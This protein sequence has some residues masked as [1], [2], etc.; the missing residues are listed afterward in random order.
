[1]GSSAAPKVRFRTTEG[2]A[3]STA[4]V[5]ARGN[6]LP[7][8]LAFFKTSCPI[9]QLT[10]P[11]LQRLHR[12]YGAKAVHVVGVSQNDAD[13]SRAYYAEHGGATFDLLLDS[14][15]TFAA[16]NAFGVESVPHLVLLSPE[17]L[18]EDVFAGWSR[19]RMEALGARF[20]A[21]N[22]PFM[23]VIPPGDPVRDSA[24]G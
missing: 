10:W 5:V 15:P 13:S 17:G 4:D 16:S 18:V 7:V 20:V 24:P 6:G 1:M 19:A 23:P 14:E 3:L 11:Y 12:A 8:L 22:V 21:K 2:A 9:C